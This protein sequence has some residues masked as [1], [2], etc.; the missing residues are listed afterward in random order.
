MRRNGKLQD[1]IPKVLLEPDM[2]PLLP[3]DNPAITFESDNNFFVSEAGN[4]SHLVRCTPHSSY[5]ERIQEPTPAFGYP[6]KEGSGDFS[7][8]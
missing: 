5:S 8:Y 3:N 4:L 1:F 2:A 6:S 7:T